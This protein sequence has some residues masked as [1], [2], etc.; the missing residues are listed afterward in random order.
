MEADEA[1]ARRDEQSDE[2]ERRDHGFLSA[3]AAQAIPPRAADTMTIR[4]IVRMADTLD[5]VISARS[6]R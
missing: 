4:Q 2:G 6:R 5:G 1:V 3:T